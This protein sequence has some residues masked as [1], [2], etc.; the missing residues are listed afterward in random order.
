MCAGD[1]L[2]R[3]QSELR[4]AHK[5]Q[6]ELEQRLANISAVGAV[7]DP[8]VA[9]LRKQLNAA[10][11]ELNAANTELSALEQC[12]HDARADMHAALSLA[13]TPCA[14]GYCPAW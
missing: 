10:S 8:L 13:Y 7:A 5:Q 12:Y 14:Q 2:E 6:Q 3:R 4:H 11:V 1:D 9:V